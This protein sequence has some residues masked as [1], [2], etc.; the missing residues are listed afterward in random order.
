M[1]I[2]ILVCQLRGVLPGAAKKMTSKIF[3]KCS[4]Q[5]KELQESREWSF[6]LLSSV[7]IS[8][9]W[10]PADNACIES[11]WYPSQPACLACIVAFGI[12]KYNL[13]RPHHISKPTLSSIP[14]KKQNVKTR[15]DYLIEEWRSSIQW[16][17][18]FKLPFA[19]YSYMRNL[20]WNKRKYLMVLIHE[21]DHKCRHMCINEV[22]LTFFNAKAP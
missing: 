11:K 3:R 13:P 7:D 12:L 22:P 8:T 5:I 15:K 1:A 6:W 19:I 4:N 18:S 16:R 20:L 10:C 17:W 9:E 2:W 14:T 21:V